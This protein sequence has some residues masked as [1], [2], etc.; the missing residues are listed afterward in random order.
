MRVGDSNAILLYIGDRALVT[1]RAKGIILYHSGNVMP[2]IILPLSMNF[3]KH[4]DT[5]L[6]SNRRAR[7][8]LVVNSLNLSAMEYQS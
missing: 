8:S 3:S 5:L 1:P 2:S 7:V 6:F 4:S